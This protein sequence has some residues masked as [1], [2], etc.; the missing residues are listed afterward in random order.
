MDDEALDPLAARRKMKIEGLWLMRDLGHG[1]LVIARSDCGYVMEVKSPSNSACRGMACN[2]CQKFMGCQARMKGV[3]SVE[4]VR[5]QDLGGQRLIRADH[6]NSGQELLV[7][8]GPRTLWMVEGQAA[9]QTDDGERILL[10]SGDVAWRL[11]GPGRLIFHQHARFLWFEAED[12][13]GFDARATAYARLMQTYNLKVG[14]A[15]AAGSKL[16][17]GQIWIDIGT[18]TGAMV[19]ALQERAPLWVIGVDQASRML[20]QAWHARPTKGASWFVSRDLRDLSWPQS[21]VDG[22]SALLVLH[23]VEE[24]DQL[25]ARIY[26]ALKPGGW[27][28]YAVSADDNPFMRMVMQ[29]LDGVGSFFQRGQ[30]KILQSALNAGFDLMG[31]ERY[32][33]AIHLDHPQQMIELMTSIGPPAS[34]GMRSDVIPPSTITRHFHL[35]WMQKK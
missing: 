19:D 35:V 9:W 15:L 20:D 31:Q 32:R 25:M 18:G 14:Q 28:A 3:W 11:E 23:L 8:P 6:R 7:D 26:R 34:R 17:A 22:V 4:V 1:H 12:R 13:L 21:A 24:I 30:A 33:D 27:L 29:Q 2:A 5:I 10:Q 16:Q